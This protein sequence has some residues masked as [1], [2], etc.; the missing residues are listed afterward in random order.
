MQD[1]N[2]EH[3]RVDPYLTPVLQ[4]KGIMAA[5]LRLDLLHAVVSGNKWF[6]LRFYID[7]ALKEN[8]NTLIT[9]GGAWSNHIHATAAAGKLHGL[10]T[11]GIIRGEA[12]P[13]LS[14][15]L[16]QA[17]AMGMELH[18]VS[19]EKYRQKQMPDHIDIS[20]AQFIP[21]GGYGATGAKGAASILSLIN[22]DDYTHI[23]CA[24]GSG[25][26]MAG[27][28]NAY[29]AKGLVTG[30]SA[31]KNNHALK[32]AVSDL[33]EAP[34]TDPE[35]IHD[36]HFGGFAKH[37]K[38]LLDFMNELYRHTRIP[39]DIV[40]TGKLCFAVN[41]LARKNYF[42]PGSKILLIHSGGLQ[43]NRSL[44]NGSLIF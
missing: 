19:R 2:L 16:Q 31:L 11:V 40:Y 24:V 18:F 21:E 4:E 20:G 37:N 41:D 3:I 38:V 15:T 14:A 9:F 26:M 44:P 22:P 43:G 34:K 25:T 5:M 12:A 1:I 39:T 8:K 32:Y 6:K 13:V 17:A 10:K 23:C 30:I 7:Q 33:L 27:L 28:I 36:Y 42:P 35:I 29:R